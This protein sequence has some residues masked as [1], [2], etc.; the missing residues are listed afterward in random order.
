MG[1]NILEKSNNY[2]AVLRKTGLAYENMIQNNG[3][4]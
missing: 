2:R 4:K 3:K 1:S